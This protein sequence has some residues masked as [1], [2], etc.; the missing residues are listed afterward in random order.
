M[1]SSKKEKAKFLNSL[2]PSNNF[3]FRATTNLDTKLE[4]LGNIYGRLP[5]SPLTICLTV[6]FPC[7]IMK[8]PILSLTLPTSFRE[9]KCI[10]IYNE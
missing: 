5:Y 9:Y 7:Q 8:F 4:S 6:N 10:C 3:P 1:Y 2:C